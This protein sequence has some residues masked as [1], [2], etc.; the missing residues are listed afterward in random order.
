MQLTI[1]VQGQR[2]LSRNLRIFADE[3]QQLSEFYTAAIDIVKKRSDDIF[4]A[5]GSN[6]EK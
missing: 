2:Q 5:K 3:L 6:V 4:A 1:D